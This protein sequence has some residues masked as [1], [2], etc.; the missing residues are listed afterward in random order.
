VAGSFVLTDGPLEGLLPL[1]PPP[2]AGAVAAFWGRVRNHHQGRSVTGLEYSAY[3]ELALKEGEAILAEARARFD[4]VGVRAAHRVGLL[5]VGDAAVVIEAASGHRAE[6]F[7]ACRWIL[8]EIKARVPIWKHE[9]YTEGDSQWVIPSPP[10][11]TTG[12]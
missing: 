1:V 5:A 3:P 12:T 10:A 11:T 9:H 6:A 7:D 4:L 2:E 8:E